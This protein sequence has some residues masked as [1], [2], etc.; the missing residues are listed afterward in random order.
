MIN[1]IRTKA[2]TAVRTYRPVSVSKY[3]TDRNLAPK[4]HNTAVFAEHP[5][6]ATSNS[7]HIKPSETRRLEV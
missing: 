4:K 7:R 2:T 3:T 6:A 5:F 1:D